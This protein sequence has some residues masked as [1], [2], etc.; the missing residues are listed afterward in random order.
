MPLSAGLSRR[1]VIA[2]LTALACPRGAGATARAR[3]F[4]DASPWNTALARTATF[5]AAFG[6]W[7]I[8]LTNWVEDGGNVA[9]H[10]AAPTDPLVSIRHVDDSWTPVHELRWRRHGNSPQV[11][12]EIRAAAT[13]GN[14]WA[15]NPYAV[16]SA[17]PDGAPQPVFPPGPI[18]G[19]GGAIPGALR[20]HCPATALPA[21]DRDGHT[22][23]MQPDGQAMEIYAPVRLRNGDWVSHMFGY[24]AADGMGDGHAN[25]RRASLLPSYAGIVTATD[26]RHGVID[27]AVAL[28][29]PGAALARTFVSPALAFD[30]DSR[31]YAG[32]VPMGARLCIPAAQ[33]GSWT[34][35][36]AI[37]GM[38]A[39]ALQRYGG[40]VVDRGGGGISVVVQQELAG[41]PE[42]RPS[43]AAEADL[44]WIGRQLR[45]TA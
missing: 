29:L 38:L 26:L 11:E 43:R 30:S 45:R 39:R 7:P 1:G 6:D 13:D 17:L 2:S 5:G 25:G 14:P 23:I 42:V 9:I 27:H 3:F 24:T 41:E 33:A 19:L 16:Q 18:A 36:S 20:I 15:V 34:P 28:L 21:P 35:R 8:G 12:A 4:C 22:V 44:R 31:D 10:W 40:Y 37:G 32:E